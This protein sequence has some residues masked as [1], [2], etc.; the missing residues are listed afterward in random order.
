M[1]DYLGVDSIKKQLNEF[2]V[3]VDSVHT[4]MTSLQNLIEC[5]DESNVSHNLDDINDNLDQIWSTN[6]SMRRSLSSQEIDVR[7][8]LS[9]ERIQRDFHILSELSTIME[10]STEHRISS[11]SNGFD[12]INGTNSET[13]NVIPPQSVGALTNGMPL[14]NITN[15]SVSTATTEAN[16]PKLE[17]SIATKS[18]VN[19][20]AISTKAKKVTKTTKTTKT[21]TKKK[22]EK[23]TESKTKANDSVLSIYDFNDDEANK[24]NVIPLIPPQRH[25]KRIRSKRYSLSS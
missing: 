13:P 10:V 25:S 8:R 17:T 12:D 24:E 16:N 20:K 4:I 2:E 5:N 1:E 7:R 3:R 15:G 11:L 18:S 22:S 19:S 23:Q 9:S 14:V 21:K 6:S